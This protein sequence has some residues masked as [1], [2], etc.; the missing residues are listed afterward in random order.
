MKH[1]TD[2]GL[3]IKKALKNTLG[4][5]GAPAFFAIAFGVVAYRLF[6]KTP[7]VSSGDIAS[8]MQAIGAVLAIF[9]AIWIGGRQTVSSQRLK[10]KSILAI[11]EA[12]HGHADRFRA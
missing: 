7:P 6:M 4:F 3:K 8:W 11:A 10:Q 5:L 2:Y 1:K 12:A 9:A